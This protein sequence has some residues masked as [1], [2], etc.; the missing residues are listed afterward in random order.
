[1]IL[2]L[3]LISRL[4]PIYKKKNFTFSLFVK[5]NYGKYYFRVSFA[6]NMGKL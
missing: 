5:A 4:V 3:S 6:N 1:M 2:S